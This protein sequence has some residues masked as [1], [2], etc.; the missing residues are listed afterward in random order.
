M[1]SFP[2][3]RMQVQVTHQTAPEIAEM[4]R[5]LDEQTAKWKAKQKP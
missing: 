5:R 3:G 4:N 2:D 1:R